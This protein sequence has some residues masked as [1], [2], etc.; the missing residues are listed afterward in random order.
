MGANGCPA[1]S[2]QP[3]E[4]AMPGGSEPL[5]VEAR[6]AG[7]GPRPWVVLV[8]L[9]LVSLAYNWYY[10]TGG[11]H[12]DDLLLI[13]LLRE[14]PLRFSRWLGLW[15]T[16]DIPAL[17]SLWWVD[18]GVA[19][20]FCRPLTSLVFE[21]SIRLFGETAF[22]LHLLSIVLHGLVAG[23]L[24][25]FVRRLTGRN[26]LAILVGVI[27]LSCEDHSLTVG[28]ITTVADILC[29]AFILLAL[30]AHVAWLQRRR[31]L[32]LAVALMALLLSLGFKESAVVA[33]VLVVLATL[34][35]PRG[36]DATLPSL[37]LSVLRARAVAALRDPLSWAPAVLVF[38]VYLAL[39]KTLG[40]G[41]MNNLAYV[42]PLSQPVA[43]LGHLV[44][45]LPVMW[46]ATLTPVFPSMV[47]FMPET[48]APQALLGLVVFAVWLLLL[49]PLRRWALVLWGMAA[50]L[51]A[52]LPQLG[53]DASE[54]LL[55]VPYVGAAVL[56]GC[57]IVQIGPLARRVLPEPGP[58]K[59]ARAGGWLTLLAVVV[60]G[61]V[62]SAYYPYVML[63]SLVAP[64]RQALT[65]LPH[66]R[67]SRAEH[68]LVLN[69][70]GMFMTLYAS[71]VLEYHQ[72]GYVDLRLLSSC[73]GVLSVER[74][75]GDSFVLRSD[76]SGWLSNMFARIFRTRPLAA[77]RVYDTDLFQATLLELTADGSDVLEVRF[78]LKRPLEDPSLL[79]LYWDG[80][81]F[82]PLDV[83]SLAPGT[84][85]ELADTSDIW[86]GML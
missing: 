61:A 47:M 27:Y 86:A 39:Y 17:M 13:N 48:L 68:I 16:I 50:Y 30:N 32:A 52:L 78:D 31:P 8:G 54:R 83:A 85:V 25:L 6:N 65:A 56:L 72:G 81:G 49:W 28:W 75:P 71:S 63:P 58:G 36:T 82:E 66:V 46:L 12:A 51:L 57:L 9:L 26:L 59:L 76:R 69:T 18:P 2:R 84:S 70:S 3:F 43:Y 80:R 11:F 14:D 5:D 62:L 60:P 79:F 20:A 53:A 55:Y 7:I 34:C 73:N 1:S 21:G 42:D 40:L 64:E 67:E 41:G 33:P 29:L 10:L 24:Y 4:L 22:P 77:G 37:G 44:V 35:F 23:G 38:I 19:G 15:S 45:H 74:L